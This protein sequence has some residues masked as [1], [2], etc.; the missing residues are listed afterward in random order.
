MRNSRY[1]RLGWLRCALAAVVTWAGAWEVR[2]DDV[3]TV[4]A[5]TNEPTANHLAVFAREGRGMLKLAGLLATGGMETGQDTHSQ[6]G[7]A[8]S[9]DHESLYAVNSGDTRSLSAPRT[10]RVTRRAAGSLLNRCSLSLPYY[11]YG[12]ATIHTH[13]PIDRLR[14]QF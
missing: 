12:L 7:L 13:A 14:R 1:N 6:R 3:K 5:L 11:E 2:G 8:F 4:Y 9:D 10:S